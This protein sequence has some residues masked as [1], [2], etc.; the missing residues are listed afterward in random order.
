MIYI[1]TTMG[2]LSPAES[3]FRPAQPDLKSHHQ[4]WAEQGHVKLMRNRAQSS[5][6]AGL[7]PK[8]AGYPAVSVRAH[9]HA[10]NWLVRQNPASQEML[11]LSARRQH[12][13]RLKS[14][15]IEC[16]LQSAALMVKSSRVNYLAFPF[17]RGWMRAGRRDLPPLHP[18]RHPTVYTTRAECH[19]RGA[20]F[21]GGPHAKE[22]PIRS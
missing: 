11:H 21:T 13:E 6:P 4:P 7:L 12:R 9:T 19:K 1:K 15:Q 20:S 16:D 3:G 8:K 18:Q 2:C 10:V 5:D 17:Y 22:T 14:C